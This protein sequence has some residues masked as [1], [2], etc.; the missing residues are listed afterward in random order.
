M[1]AATEVS[2]RGAVPA[3]FDRIVAVADEWW[4]MPVSHVVPRLFLDHFH[5][6]SFVAEDFSG[7]LAGFVLGFLSPS[8]PSQ[9]YV[10]FAGVRPDQ[11]RAGLA[12]ELYERFFDL[13]RKAGRTRV[14]AIT[15]PQN[16]QSIAYHTRIGFTVSNPIENYDG[17]GITRVVFERAL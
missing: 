11:R 12:S 6:T 9:A 2:V 5:D 3:D 13:A 17:P 16:E 4:S 14:G 10:H 15:S 1:C 7:V 8:D